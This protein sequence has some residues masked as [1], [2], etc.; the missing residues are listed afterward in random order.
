MTITILQLI[1]IY[2]IIGVLTVWYVNPLGVL[3]Q[4]AENDLDLRM[5]PSV[6]NFIM[7]VLIIFC[8]CLWPLFMASC[9]AFAVARKI[10]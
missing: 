6:I 4:E 3:K 2:A 5:N 1:I 9:I 10:K 7:Y 8:G